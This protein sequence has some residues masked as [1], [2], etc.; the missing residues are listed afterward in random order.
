MP[1]R[2]SVLVLALLIG[3]CGCV[4]DPGEEPL[5]NIVYILADDLGI[6]DLSCYNAGSQLETTHLD[7]LAAGGLRFNDAH[8]GSAVCTPTRYG[9]L[10]G[11]YAWRSRLKNGVLWS[12]DPHL[13][14]PAQ[15]TVGSLLQQVDYHTA[16]IGKW[17]L[18]LDW[19][20]DSLE[21]IRFNEPIQNGPIELGFDYFFGITAS[22][23]IPPYFYIDN[24]IITSNTVDT[25]E[26]M[27]G[28]KFWREGPVGED[29]VHEEVLP[30]LTEKAVEYIE[31]QA[32]EEEP[33][34]LYFPLPAPH[35]PILPTEKFQGVS[36]TNEYGDFVLMVD[37]VVGQIM[38]ALEQ[39]GEADN[40]LVI[41]TSDNGCSPMA[42]FEE[43]AGAGHDPSGIYRGHKADIFEGGHRVPYIASWPDRISPG[44]TE[45]TICLTDLL[46]TTAAITGQDLPVRA[47]EDSY[48]LL[49]LML[50]PDTVIQNVREA[51]VHHSINGSFAIRKGEWKLAFCPGSGGWSYPRPQVADSLDM[52]KLQLYNLDD[53]PG[54]EHNVQAEFPQ[55]VEAL[56]TLMQ[57][58]IDE[59]RS[60][61][62]PRM[63]NEGVTELIP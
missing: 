39:T 9:I 30:V 31:K 17:H 47:G 51:T 6:G 1:N 38:A 20:T 35:T 58:Y 26:A 2:L 24:N 19:S 37:D 36:G 28:K 48:N 52:P 27:G 21:N 57:Q 55:I 44:V 40:T 41:F 16:C 14:E 43:L 45:Q 63:Q 49:P 34:F 54:E 12:Y 62:G 5:P 29:F 59:G 56:S 25:I 7:Q 10:T 23:D 32:L 61:P 8:S 50:S 42:N 18:G 53:D 15:M 22:L 46:A 33:F 4:T 3:L 60:T 13:I 11:R